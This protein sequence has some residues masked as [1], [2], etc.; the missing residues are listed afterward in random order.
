[1]GCGWMYV[2][3]E[4]QDSGNSERRQVNGLQALVFNVRESLVG[5][6]LFPSNS[7]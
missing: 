4:V 3:L 6:V 2:S 5:T 7:N 1:M